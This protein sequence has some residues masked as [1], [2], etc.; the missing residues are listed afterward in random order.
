[1]SSVF[2]CHGVRTGALASSQAPHHS[3]PCKHVDSFALLLVLSKPKHR[4]GFVR[5][6]GG[7]DVELSGLPGKRNGASPFGRYPLSRSSFPGR[8]SSLRPG[9]AGVRYAPRRANRLRSR[10]MP[11]IV[12]HRDELWPYSARPISPPRLV[13]G[14]F[15]RGPTSPFGVLFLSG[16]TPFLSARAERNGVDYPMCVA[17]A[18]SSAAAQKDRASQTACPV[19]ICFCVISAGCSAHSA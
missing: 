8:R 18:T 4:F 15:Q 17:Q 6:N 13:A 12:R 10:Q 1:M 3:S 9:D 7:A 11:A 5:R 16:T 2:L 19:C 14:G